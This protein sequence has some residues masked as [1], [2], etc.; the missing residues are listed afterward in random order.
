MADALVQVEN[1]YMHFRLGGGILGK[2][3]QTVQA[4]NGVS[5]EIPEGSTFSLVGESGC[6]K[7]TT[8]RAILRLIQPT[9]G[10]VTFDGRTVFNINTGKQATSQEMLAL[11]RDMQMIFQDPYACLDPRM[12][13]GSIVTEG[14]KKH[15]LAQ[16]NAAFEMAADMLKLC[17]MERDC[18][19]RYPHEFSGGQR[20]RIG[21]ARSLAIKPKFIVAD[22]PIAALDV[23]IQAQILNLL[24]DLQEQLKLTYLFISHDLGV[25]RRF[26]DHIG[27]MYLGNIME[28]GKTEDVYENPRHPYT[29]A[30]LSAIPSGQ[31]GIH[32]KRMMLTGELPSPVNPPSGCRFHTR[33]PHAKDI[34][35]QAVPAMEDDG[36]GRKVACHFWKEI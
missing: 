20:Q 27:I 9:G 5:F 16:G 29:R 13:I 25:V 17:G 11:R 24:V 28:C 34:C 2:K 26:C 21:I 14:I 7:S 33:C 36:T 32:K 6:G 8:G 12:N 35:R 19:K 30:L 18:L 3:H 23:S 15:K 10:A 4:V 22:E 31:P 1:L